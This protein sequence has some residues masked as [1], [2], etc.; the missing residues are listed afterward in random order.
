MAVALAAYEAAGAEDALELSVE[1][2]AGHECTLG[3]WATVH[4]WLDTMLRPA[5]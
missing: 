3:M 2:E 1:P 4:A 5:T